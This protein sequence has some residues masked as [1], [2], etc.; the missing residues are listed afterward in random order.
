MGI[1]ERKIREFSKRRDLILGTAQA[2][3]DQSG[4][5]NVTLLDIANKIE[6]SKGTIY[7]H[8]S[9]KEE[10]YARILLRQLNALLTELKK[11]SRTSRGTISGIKRSL[12]TYTRFYKHHRQYFK[13]LFFFDLVSNHYRIPKNLL[14]EIKSK[15]LA[16]LV[17]LQNIIRIDT[18]E[19]TPYRE[20]S[21]VLWGMINGII[22]LIE[23]SQLKSVDLDRLTGIGFDIV[24]RGI[25]HISKKS[26]MRC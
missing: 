17:Q 3:F 5:E 24:T 25:Q 14:K 2:L 12:T 15:K 10:I 18:G 4:L 9:S 11:V 22:H 16:C 20:I 6:F 26:T 7:S 19:S 23:S 8:F 13:L 1:K 21:F